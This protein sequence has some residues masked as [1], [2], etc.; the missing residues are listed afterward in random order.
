MVTRRWLAG[1]GGLVAVLAGVAA[2]SPGRLHARQAGGK[3]TFEVYQDTAKEYRWR[4]KAADGAVLATSGQG[5][6]A[7]ADCKNGVE[8]I[9]KDAAD[10]L[11]FEVYEDAKKEFRWRVKAPNGQVIGSSGAGYK[12]KADA[13][14]AVAAIKA[15]AAKA[16]VEDK[17]STGA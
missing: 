10:K 14:K 5:Y 6:K 12:A 7:K 8:R 4:L 17:T 16:A 2:V 3:L 13:E 11:S 9:R 1:V 15:G